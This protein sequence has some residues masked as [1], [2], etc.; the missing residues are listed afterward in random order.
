MGFDRRSLLILPF[1]A[2]TALPAQA[3]ATLTCDAADRLVTFSLQGNVGRDAGAIVQVTSGSLQVKAVRGKHDSVEL[4]LEPAH[5]AQQW[6]FERELRL[7][8]TAET[9]QDVTIHL[10][11]IAQ[12]TKSGDDGDRYQGRYVLKLTG[13]KGTSELKG[14][15]KGCEAG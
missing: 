1:L 12:R 14:S 3:T 7:R 13:A 9:K 15:L 4:T 6:A 5:L 11:I 10:A 8:L 2:A